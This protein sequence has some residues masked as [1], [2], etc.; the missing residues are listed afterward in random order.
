MGTFFA[1]MGAS[2][3]FAIFSF[4]F[5][6]YQCWYSWNR[7]GTNLGLS[8]YL[9][10][11]GGGGGGLGWLAATLAKASPTPIAVVNGIMFG[12]GGALVLRARVSSTR[13]GKVEHSATAVEQTRSTSGGN[14][15]PGRK[16]ELGCHAAG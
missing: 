11:A 6:L 1:A 10:L 8:L 2:A 13:E 9:A 3:V 16:H 14:V 7:L 4:P 15:R 5:R 12:I